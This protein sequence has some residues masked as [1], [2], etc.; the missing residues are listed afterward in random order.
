MS[1]VTIIKT[2]SLEELEASYKVAYRYIRD[3]EDRLERARVARGLPAIP[4]SFNGK[5]K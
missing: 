3:L 5:A 4:A 2:Y 1:N